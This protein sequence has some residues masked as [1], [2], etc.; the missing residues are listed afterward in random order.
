MSVLVKLTRAIIATMAVALLW[1]T[2]LA[3]E[4]PENDEPRRVSQE[5]IARIQQEIRDLHAERFQVWSEM[6]Q[7]RRQEKRLKKRIPELTEVLV[8]LQP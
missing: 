1:G 2:V 7:L 6:G 3:Q 8:E 5:E 4:A